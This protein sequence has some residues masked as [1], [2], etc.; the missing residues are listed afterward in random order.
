[1]GAPGNAAD[2]WAEA[3]T[4]PVTKTWWDV[5]NG[6]EMDEASGSLVCGIC[7]VG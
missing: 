3:V 6:L 2:V 1:M 5:S 7:G 4:G